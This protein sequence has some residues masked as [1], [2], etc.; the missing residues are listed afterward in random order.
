MFV[1][2]LLVT[3]GLQA[4]IVQY[5]SIAFHVSKGGLSA[6]YWGWS[7][8]FGSFELIVQQVINVLYRIGQNS[9]IHRNKTRSQKNH[10]LITQRTNGTGTGE[11]KHHAE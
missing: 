6:K 5:G 9:K 4:I 11:Q 1:G 3:S 8:L 10:H 2:I 7:L